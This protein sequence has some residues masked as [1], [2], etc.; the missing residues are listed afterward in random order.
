MNVNN[1]DAH[2]MHWCPQC[3]SKAFS[4]KEKLDKHQ[5]LCFNYEVVKTLLTK[6]KEQS[7]IEAKEY[8]KLAEEKNKTKDDK[9]KNI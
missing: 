1:T 5:E 7:I 2:K 4:S 6:T 3:L 8:N 9:Y